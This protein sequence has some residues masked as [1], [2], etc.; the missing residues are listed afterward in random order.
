[1]CRCCRSTFLRA[2]YL[3][4]AYFVVVARMTAT[5]YFLFIFAF[6]CSSSYSLRSSLRLCASPLL[7][8]SL[9]PHMFAGPSRAGGN[10]CADKPR[11]G[12]EN[13]C[14]PDFLPVVRPH[15]QKRGGE[16]R[17]CLVLHESVSQ[18]NGS[19]RP[20]IESGDALSMR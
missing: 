13:C 7:P 16:S 3:F 14:C 20:A 19:L 6:F 15:V 18:I 17:T 2:A 11:C 5:F 1:M 4:V 12:R 10:S 9:F 8:F